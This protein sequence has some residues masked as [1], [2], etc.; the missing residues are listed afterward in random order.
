MKLSE[1]RLQSY[2][3][4]TALVIALA[5]ID[6]AS[7][8]AYAEAFAALKCRLAL[9]ECQNGGCSICRPDLWRPEVS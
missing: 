2:D 9:T 7:S 5:G 8:G 1:F 6:A 4:R 3:E